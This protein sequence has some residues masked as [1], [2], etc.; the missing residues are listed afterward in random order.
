MD[1][2]QFNW[3]FEAFFILDVFVKFITEFKK[4]HEAS[5]ERDIKEIAKH[6]LRT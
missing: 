2:F 1:T 4:P 3:F 6:Y 5:P